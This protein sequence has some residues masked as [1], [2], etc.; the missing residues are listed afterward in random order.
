M[1]I[2]IVKDSPRKMFI[3]YTHNAGEVWQEIIIGQRG[4]V[5]DVHIKSQYS[6]RCPIISVKLKNQR[7][8][9]SCI[10]GEYHG[11]YTGLQATTLSPRKLRAVVLRQRTED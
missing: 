2:K 7:N 10:P 9:C 11:F 1:R 6:T 4:T 3:V 5:G 8:M